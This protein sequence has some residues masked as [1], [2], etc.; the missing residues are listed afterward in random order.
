MIN[1]YSHTIWCDDIRQEIGNK[2]SFMGV[3]TSQLV[4]PSLPT[5]LPR[6]SLAL[7][8]VTPKETPFEKLSIKV[9]HSNGKSIVEI[10]PELSPIMPPLTIHPDTTRQQLLVCFSMGNVELS[11]ESKYLEVQIETESGVL[12]ASKL[13][14]LSDP[15]IFDQFLAMSPA[16]VRDTDQAE[17]I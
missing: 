4:V 3:Y 12:P 17:K 5:V 10:N 15:K 13:L 14:I 9:L 1:R 11:L 16:G 7:W 2:P 6:L 8:I